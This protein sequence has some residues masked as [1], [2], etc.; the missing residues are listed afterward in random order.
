LLREPLLHFFILG[1][2]LFA[3]FAWVNRNAMYAPDEIVISDSLLQ[4]MQKQFEGTWQRPPSQQEL[5]GLIDNWTR[6]EIL[7]REG[8]ALG[9][10]MDDAVI[11]RRIVQ[12][13][14]FITDSMTSAMPDE[15][16]LQA[17][18]D[19]HPEDYLIPPQYSFKQIYFDPARHTSDLEQ[20]M[21]A[22]L[23]KLLLGDSIV[24]GDSSL[25]PASLDDTPEQLVSRTFGSKFA[26]EL[27]DL[28]LAEWVGPVRSGF[29]FHLVY[30]N[31]A[32]PGRA[33]TLDEVRQAVENDLSNDQSKKTKD[34]MYQVLRDRYTVIYE[35]PVLDSD[36]SAPTANP[37]PEYP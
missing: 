35:N 12:K 1:L 10:D 25:L 36:E 28:P 7:F 18:L 32:I 5:R 24:N 2:L 6:E 15:A 23:Q 9:L 4:S 30:V 20:V 8:L 33:A 3:L 14:D 13:M 17:W 34:A 22:A 27:A 26:K 19:E 21:L 16:A 11:R 31:K 29:G 37:E